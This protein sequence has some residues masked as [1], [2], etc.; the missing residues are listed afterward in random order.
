MSVNRKNRYTEHQ[1]NRKNDLHANLNSKLHIIH[2]CYY[3]VEYKHNILISHTEMYHLGRLKTYIF[4]NLVRRTSGR[5]IFCLCTKSGNALWHLGVSSFLGVNSDCLCSKLN[6]WF[7]V[8]FSRNAAT[9]SCEGFGEYP[10]NVFP[11]RC[12]QVISNC[13]HLTMPLNC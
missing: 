4:F 11:V 9:C 13:L 8:R 2:R 7:F 12:I 1:I 5:H 6:A 10:Q 3:L